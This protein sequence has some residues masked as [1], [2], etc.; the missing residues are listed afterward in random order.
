[1]KSE[2]VEL[3]KLLDQEIESYSKLESYIVEKKNS[4]IKGDIE[5]L[6]YIDIE[7]EKFN[8]VISKLEGK[9]NQISK[10][11]GDENL[12]LKE[13]IERIDNDAE[14]KRLLNSREKLLNIVNNVQKQNKTNKELLKHALKLV[15]NSINI[16]ANVLIPEC[17]A[18]NNYGKANK[19]SAKIS[20]I[21]QEA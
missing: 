4:L 14:S 20:S 6:K 10:K 19:A 18:Y 12:T 7:I 13:I 1:M 16:I 17:S 9:K 2:V 5:K 11:F 8:S 21:V 3:E 15:E